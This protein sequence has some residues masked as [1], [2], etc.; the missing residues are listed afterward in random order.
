MADYTPIE[1]MDADDLMNE[2]EFL[3]NELDKLK[4]ERD[5]FIFHI[6]A[7]VDLMEYAHS[8]IEE[9]EREAYNRGLDSAVDI[10]SN[11]FSG[12]TGDD[13]AHAEEEIMRELQNLRK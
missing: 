10:F 3:R 13:L 12:R 2:V 7:L 9:A 1:E 6:M 5:I 11:A 4:K 8:K